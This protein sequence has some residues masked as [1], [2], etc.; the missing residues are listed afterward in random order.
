MRTV[1]QDLRYAVRGLLKAPSFIVVALMSLALGIGATTALFSVIYGVLIAPYP[2]AK[3]D[4][5]WAPSVRSL[6]SGQG[7]HGYTASEFLELQKAPM[8]SDVMATRY[9]QVL[10]TGDRSPESFGGVVVSANAFNFLGVPPILGRT[11]QPTD[12]RV[13]GEPEP[14]VELTYGFWQ[15]LFAGDPSA[16]G[17]TLVLNGVPHTVIGVMPPRFGWYTNEAFWLPMAVNT[18]DQRGVNPIFRLKSGVTSDSAAQ[19]LHALNLQFASQRPGTFPRDGFTTVLMNYLDV[20]VASGQMRSSLQLL[21]AAVGFLLLIACANVANLQLARNASRSR[22]IVVRLAIGAGRRRVV[23]QLLTESFL[24]SLSGGT[25][26]V[27]LAFATTNAIVALMPTFYVPNEARV[28]VNSSVLLF[29]LGVSVLTGVLS[30]ITPA[31][32]CSRPDL[33][34]ALN[35]GA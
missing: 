13:D 3:P 11:I 33:V 21:F 19:Q 6:K 17:K 28:T 32:Q 30:G 15:R 27:A 31:L 26:G 29:S 7:G 20:T 4:E 14:V 9:Q 34:L 24:L 35:E 22:E 1:G 25:L 23:R 10:M 2:Y 16:L 12:V 18:Q 8:F 5:I